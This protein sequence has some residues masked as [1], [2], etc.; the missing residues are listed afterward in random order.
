M[1]LE[2]PAVGLDVLERVQVAEQAERFVH[3]LVRAALDRGRERLERDRVHM[4]ARHLDRMVLNRAEHLE[5]VIA[6]VRSP[7]HIVASVANRFR[8]LVVA[9]RAEL[10]DGAAHSP[11]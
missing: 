8:A 6:L 4:R 2:K 9:L 1:L 3:G 11:N 7:G 10:V 5:R